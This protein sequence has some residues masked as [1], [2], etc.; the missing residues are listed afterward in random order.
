L[1]YI[2]GKVAIGTNSIWVVKVIFVHW[3]TGCLL[4]FEH[5]WSCMV[6]LAVVEC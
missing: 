2:Y 4:S 6:N 1:G 5:V 3:T